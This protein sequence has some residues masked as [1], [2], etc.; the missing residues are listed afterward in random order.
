MLSALFAVCLFGLGC[1]RAGFRLLCNR[2]AV[3]VH[4]LFLFGRGAPACC[5]ATLTPGKRNP[6]TAD[7]RKQALQIREK[8]FCR[9]FTFKKSEAE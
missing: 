1:I 7:Q 6:E 8:L 3:H 5:R 2:W 9:S 4:S